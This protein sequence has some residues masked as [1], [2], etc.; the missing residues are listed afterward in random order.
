MKNTYSLILNAEAEEKNRSIFELAVYGLFLLSMA[1]SGWQF[2]STSV[3][4]PSK[5]KKQDAPQSMIAEAPAPAPVI[6]S[7]G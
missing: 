4:L 2:A 6:A 1:F 3:T 5:A 7:R